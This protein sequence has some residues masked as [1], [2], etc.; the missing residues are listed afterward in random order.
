[1]EDT[2]TTRSATKT[3]IGPWYVLQ[4][5]NPAAPGMKWTTL[6]AL[7]EKGQVT[8]RS[9]V[10]GPTTHQ[11][12][13]FAAHVKGLSR[14]FGLCYSCGSQIDKTT[15]QCP[16]CERLQELPPNPDALLEAR[17]P[18]I[19]REPV[20]REI[21]SSSSMLP[22]PAPPRPSAMEITLNP[23]NEVGH[24]PDPTEALEE[25][26][27]T[28]GTLPRVEPVKAPRQQQWNPDAGILSAK[29][30]AQAFQLDFGPQMNPPRRGKFLRG[31]VTFVILAGIGLTG[32]MLVWPDLREQVFTSARALAVTAQERFNKGGGDKAQ[33]PAAAAG[34]AIPGADVDTAQP[35]KRLQATV[36][37]PTTGPS[38]HPP[39]AGLGAKSS[40]PL[41][42]DVQAPAVTRQP[43]PEPAPAAQPGKTTLASDEDPIERARALWIHA[44]DAEAKQDYP[45]AIKYYEQ[46]K[47]LPQSAWPAGLEIRLQA[48]KRQLQ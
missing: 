44:I 8:P 17:E 9:V 12:W 34:D 26:R 11:L 13:R 42:A 45:D 29:E 7:V 31:I 3:R 6:L 47:K 14:E 5:R 10:R 48:A 16:N 15:H 41:T 35:P 28:R 37:A 24:P 33:S 22:P 21:R 18:Q 43:L 1:M 36:E 27:P 25:P 46:I 20:R 4:S 40:A 19:A 32:L 39:V 30:L 38:A 23:R 2:P